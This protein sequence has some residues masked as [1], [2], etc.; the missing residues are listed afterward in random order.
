MSVLLIDANFVINHFLRILK[1]EQLV[2]P[3]KFYSLCVNEVRKYVAEY[4]PDNVLVC[5]SDFSRSWRK[6]VC[7]DYISL[8]PSFNQILRMSLDLFRKKLLSID[9]KLHMVSTFEG[10]DIIFN[11]A[12]K[13]KMHSPEKDVVVIGADKR[14][15]S[16]LPM[17][18]TLI[19]PLVAGEPLVRD[20]VWYLMKFGNPNFNLTDYL[21]LVGEPSLGVSGVH[22]IGEVKAKELVE[23]YGNFE[24][25]KDGLVRDGVIGKKSES[26]VASADKCILVYRKIFS[27]RNDFNLNIFLSN[28][29][30][31]SSPVKIAV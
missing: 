16:L 8:N 3:D 1:K 23:H 31:P 11:I 26:V 29:S 17:G 19:N 20:Y 30:Y 21:C 7:S 22:G 6:A 12:S 10:K 4:K 13:I 27:L 28:F 15:W 14:L 18:V 25:M 5:I 9:V 24:N 2:N